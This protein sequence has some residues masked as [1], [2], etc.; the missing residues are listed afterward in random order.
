MLTRRS[1]SW[2]EHVLALGVGALVFAVFWATGSGDH[3]WLTVTSGLSLASAGSATVYAV[4]R[5]KERARP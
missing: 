1:R 5:A 4:G 2:S 3:G